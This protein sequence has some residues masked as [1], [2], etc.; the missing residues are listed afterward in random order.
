[1]RTET[2]KVT[3]HLPKKLLAKA[4]HNTGKGITETVRQ[5]LEGLAKADVY[6]ELMAMRGKVHLKRPLKEVLK[7][8]KRARE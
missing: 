7:E 4:Q 1:M 2:Q 5:G 3:M 8:I 6:E